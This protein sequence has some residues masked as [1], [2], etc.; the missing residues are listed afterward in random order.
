MGCYIGGPTKRINFI[1]NQDG[2]ILQFMEDINTKIVQ[3]FF[4]IYHGNAYIDI[5]T[6]ANLSYLPKFIPS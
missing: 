3:F 1:H 6:K 5:N 4:A 2:N